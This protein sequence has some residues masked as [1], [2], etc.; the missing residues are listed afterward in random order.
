MPI[1]NNVTRPKPRPHFPLLPTAK[2]ITSIPP[3]L[4]AYFKVL[5]KQAVPQAVW[6]RRQAAIDT[7]SKYKDFSWDKLNKQA[8]AEASNAMN[9]V[10][11]TYDEIFNEYRKYL[12]A[13]NLSTKNDNHNLP[14]SPG[15]VLSNA[16]IRRSAPLWHSIDPN[17]EAELRAASEKIVKFLGT[18]KIKP[19]HTYLYA[20]GI[21]NNDPRLN[22]KLVGALKDKWDWI[23]SRS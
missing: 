5:F 1:I 14:L 4:A 18:H 23:D 8:Q 3:E 16:E 12:D 22:S 10:D 11:R 6:D 20:Y 13:L 21:L 7:L 17:E 19:I 9:E 2:D 15:V